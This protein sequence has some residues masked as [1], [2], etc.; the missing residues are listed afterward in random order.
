MH[1]DNLPVLAIKAITTLSI[2]QK[3]LMFEICVNLTE[4][5]Y[6]CTAKMFLSLII[7]I[8]DVGSWRVGW[9]IA[10]HM[11]AI[12]SLI[13]ILFENFLSFKITLYP[14]KVINTI[15]YYKWNKAGNPN[16]FLC[17][18]FLSISW[19]KKNLPQSGS[20]QHAT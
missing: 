4:A 8:C 14:L 17:C 10:M 9:V 12:L 19:R 6:K 2:Q 1:I 5:K 3:N 16:C 7:E 20:F 13:F 11:I 18:L 15:R